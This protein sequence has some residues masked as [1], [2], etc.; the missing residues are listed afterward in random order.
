MVIKNSIT[1]CRR[2]QM[3]SRYLFVGMMA[4]FLIMA[5]SVTTIEAKGKKPKTDPPPPEDNPCYPLDYCYDP[6]EDPIPADQ[7]FYNPFGELICPV[8]WV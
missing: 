1:R 3:K 4:I 7:C 2:T 5:T 8:Y 6:P